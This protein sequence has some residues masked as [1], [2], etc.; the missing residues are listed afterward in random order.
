MKVE[1]EILNE[2]VEKITIPLGLKTIE[3]DAKRG[4]N[5]LNIIAVIDKDGGVTISDCEKVTRLLND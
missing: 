2:E 4:P 3:L 5:G 1:I